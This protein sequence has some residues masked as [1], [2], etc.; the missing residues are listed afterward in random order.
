MPE[1]WAEAS[2]AAQWDDDASVLSL[3]RSALVVRGAS[4][5]L[6]SGSF[7]WRDSPPGSL[8]FERVAGDDVVVCAVNFSAHALDL[9]DGDIVVASEPALAASLPAASAAWVR[10]GSG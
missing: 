9:R 10:A 2:V 3:Y 8:V 7:A 6:R 1:W 4:E 5:A